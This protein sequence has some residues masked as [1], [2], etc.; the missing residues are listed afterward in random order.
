MSMRFL[1]T[2][3][4]AAI[5]GFGALQGQQISE[6]QAQK[7]FNAEATLEEFTKAAEEAAKSG[8]PAQILAEAKLVWG[9]RNADTEYLT[10]ILPELETVAKNFKQEDSAALT[11][12]DDFNGLI[13]YI[14]ALDA[15]KR[16]DETALKK[17][18]TEAFWLSPEQG[19][20][21]GSTI[22]QFRK[23]QKMAKITADMKLPLTT[24]KGEAT[25]LGD[26]L[27]QNKAILL[28]F[29]AT[30]SGPCMNLMP[31]LRK[32][33]ELL[34]KH[35]IVVAGMNNESD[36]AK[37]DEVRAQKDMKM[38]WLVEPKGSPFS[39]LLGIDSIP[40][41]ILL[42]PDGKVLFNGHPDEPGLWT[43]LKK[44]DATIEAPKE[45]AEAKN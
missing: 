37:A 38:P 5:C 1:S 45:E 44:L 6:E 25:T 30:W 19:E 13:S 39:E 11:S 41:M 28:G 40:R 14:R 17:H 12:P 33:A 23:D 32:K 8:V 22:T 43:A 42:S 36:E 24:S 2:L 16:G 7:L 35:G 4:V 31:E 27:G 20:L 10:K 15:G 29:W 18:I 26:Q 21:F 34:K 3:V 9:L